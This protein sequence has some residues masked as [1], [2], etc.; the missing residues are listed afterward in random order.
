MKPQPKYGFLAAISVVIAN[1]IGTGVFTSLGFQV[2]DIPSGFAILV[3]WVLGGVAAFCGGVCY[4]E[5]G[6]AIPRSGG[7]YHFI[8]RIFHP[9][10]GFLSGWVSASVGFAAPTALAA[11]TFSTYLL[12]TL[13]GEA[14]AI[15]VK[16]IACSLV[17][18]LAF[19]HGSR[20]AASAGLQTFFT[21]IKVG[22][23]VAFCIAVAVMSDGRTGIELRPTSTAASSIMSG[24]FAVALIYVSYSYAGWN[25]AAYLTGEIKDAQKNLPRILAIGAGIVT[26]LYVALNAAFLFAAPVD[27][28]AGKLEV[29]YIAAKFAFGEN[30]AKFTGLVLASLLI[31]TVSAMTIAGPRV[32][33]VIGEDYPLFKPLA[34]TNA[35]NI[36][37]RA[38]YTQAAVA[39]VF[40]ITST[41]QS[42]LIFAGSLIA[43]N[44]LFTVIGMM[45]LRWKEPELTRPY[46]AFAYPI[47]P[48][49]FIGLSTWT[50]IYVVLTRPAQAFSAAALLMVGGIIYAI[51]HKKSAP[52]NIDNLN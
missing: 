15:L 25:A 14:D 48:L 20:R 44:S 50:L 41:F 17:I 2:A 36:P 47:T 38:I 1:M 21:I 51:A 35:D 39:V 8:G 33:Q 40:I 49:I 12:S 28:L 42:I 24:P 5:L 32:L 31:S 6:A 26:I 9:A 23:V 27:A 18:G 46:R 4:A 19:V 11:V 13:A 43:L 22:V 34:K 3:L 45:V 16:V 7:E 52:S 30:A 37:F 10:A 29:G